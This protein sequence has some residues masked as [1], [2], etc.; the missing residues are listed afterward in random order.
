MKIIK[1]PTKHLPN[2]KK[3]V[4]F[5]AGSIEMG[6]ATNWQTKVEDALKDTS[7]TILNPRRDDWDSS[8]VQEITN[9]QFNEQVTWEL[10]GLDDADIIAVY[11]DPVTKSP[12]TLMELGLYAQSGKLLVCCPKP[13]WRKGNVDIVCER[14]RIE[15]VDTLDEIITNLLKYEK[16][17]K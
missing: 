5:L 12:V 9:K 1:P 6:V 15:Q 7:Y 16:S 3:P 14:Y 8:W 17:F 11:F 10:D 2:Y 4:V 13:F